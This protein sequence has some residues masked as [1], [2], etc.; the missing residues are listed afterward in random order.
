MQFTILE[1]TKHSL[2]QVRSPTSLKNIRI[3]RANPQLRLGAVL[4]T[5]SD[6]R[7]LRSMSSIER[8]YESVVPFDP[9]ESVKN[10]RLPFRKVIVATYLIHEVQTLSPVILLA[11]QT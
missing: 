9:Q 8:C 2:V 10:L 6:A 4:A 5:Q 3:V 1:W 11:A 7:T